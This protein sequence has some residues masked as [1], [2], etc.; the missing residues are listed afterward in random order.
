MNKEERF[1]LVRVFEDNSVITILGSFDEICNDIEYELSKIE[2]ND[3]RFYKVKNMV[4]YDRKESD[5]GMNLNCNYVIYDE[6]IKEYPRIAYS[7][8]IDSYYGDD[9]L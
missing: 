9:S 4:V 6:T 2:T 1:I 8:F 3:K 7:E 5:S